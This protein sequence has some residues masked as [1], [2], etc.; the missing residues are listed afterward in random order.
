MTDPYRPATAKSWDGPSGLRGGPRAPSGPAR[1]ARTPAVVRRRCPASRGRP[2][3]FTPNGRTRADRGA[4]A[5]RR[6]ARRGAGRRLGAVVEHYDERERATLVFSIGLINLF[7]R[8]N[9]ATRQ[10]AGTGY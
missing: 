5:G 2:A 9:L 3:R 6:P 7:N 1:R 10:V 4:H 8:L